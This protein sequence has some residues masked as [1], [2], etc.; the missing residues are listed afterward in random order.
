MS[1]NKESI[2]IDVSEFYNYYIILHHLNWN[3]PLNDYTDITTDETIENEI[4]EINFEV[5]ESP[6]D[7]IHVTYEKINNVANLMT[8]KIL[9]LNNQLIKKIEDDLGSNI[10]S[11]EHFQKTYAPVGRIIFTDTESLAPVDERFESIGKL[12][13][14]FYVRFSLYK[15]MDKAVHLSPTINVDELQKML[16][17][18]IVKDLLDVVEQLKEEEIFTPPP[19][20]L[21]KFRSI[22][23]KS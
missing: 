2:G 20:F 23:I 21:K 19:A 6:T 7:V 12:R 16:R 22:G 9:A 3:K 18:A 15:A 4:R 13:K 17:H 11:E 14:D 8:N 1:D 10:F 5:S